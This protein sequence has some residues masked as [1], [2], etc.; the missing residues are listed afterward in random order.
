MSCIEEIGKQLI[1][2][3]TSLKPEESPE[4]HLTVHKI[5]SYPTGELS[6]TFYFF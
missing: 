5:A 6:F 1:N 2:W 4:I 3:E